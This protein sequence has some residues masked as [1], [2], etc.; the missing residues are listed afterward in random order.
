MVVINNIKVSMQT[1]NSQLVTHPIPYFQVGDKVLIKDHTREAR[2]LKFDPGHDIVA[3]QDRQVELTDMSGNAQKVNVQDVKSV[4]PM[5]DLI[6]YV[7]CYFILL[8]R[9]KCYPS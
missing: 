6:R 5:D 7:Q 8:G 3:I 2:G 9:Q 4:Y 1:Q